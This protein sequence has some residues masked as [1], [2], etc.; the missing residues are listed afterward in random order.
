MS[1]FALR[2]VDADEGGGTAGYRYYLL[3]LPKHVIDVAMVEHD[4]PYTLEDATEKAR[5]FC[6]GV[7]EGRL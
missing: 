7:G 1:A 5:A 6:A 4:G 3:R 2:F